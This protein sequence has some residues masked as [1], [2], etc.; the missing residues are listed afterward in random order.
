MSATSIIRKA[1]TTPAER[2]LNETYA[3]SADSLGIYANFADKSLAV[4][5]VGG[6]AFW[7]NRDSEERYCVG[8]KA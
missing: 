5:A 4:V 6:R 7:W 3:M 8:G 2:R 1:K